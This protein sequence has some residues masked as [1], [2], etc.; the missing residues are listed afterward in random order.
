MNAM[1]SL[2]S[3]IAVAALIALLVAL[4]NTAFAQST[5]APNPLPGVVKSPRPLQ[6]PP[7]VARPGI[8]SP[9]KVPV[10]ADPRSIGKWSA[11]S[12][13]SEDL[14]AALVKSGALKVNGNAGTLEF[15]HQYHGPNSPKHAQM[16][17]QLKAF[18]TSSAS[19]GQG[20]GQGPNLS[21]YGGPV[22]R[23]PIII[24]VFWGFN[25]VNN[26]PNSAM[27]PIGA[28][29][30][31]LSF[32]DYM[33]QSAWLA[34]VN[35]YSQGGNQNINSG[36][37]VVTQPIFDDTTSP[38]ASYGN[39]DVHNEVARLIQQG[40]ASQNTLDIFVVVTPHGSINQD[41]M[42]ANDC[43]NHGS[44][45]GVSFGIIPPTTT[46]SH[47]YTFASVPYLAD[48]VWGCWTSGVGAIT[49]A[50][51]H[52]IAETITDPYGDYF[53]NSVYGGA[54]WIVNPL[55]FSDPG[56]EIGDLCNWMSGQTTF[57]PGQSFT[58]QPLWSNQNQQCV[59]PN[60][61][62]PLYTNVSLQTANGHFVTAV[63]GGGL[64]EAGSSL[65]TDRTIP[66]A[67]E[68]FLILVDRPVGSLTPPHIALLTETGNY[69][70]ANNGG[71]MGGPNT[72]AAPMH[73]DA[74]AVNAWEKFT[75]FTTSCASSQ[76]IITLFN[77][78]NSNYMEHT[79]SCVFMATSNGNFVTTLYG[80]AY[81]GGP[82]DPFRTNATSAQAWET[83]V[84]A[85]H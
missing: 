16:V 8:I 84:M 10:H 36:L 17:A 52:E 31:I 72:S 85:G 80:G 81:G 69:V 68:T 64:G 77:W 55:Q 70:T 54:S 18:A 51:G 63:N 6:S 67:W 22:L 46:V 76:Q 60:G 66:L 25:A 2:N 43:A 45:Q 49:K 20:S 44:D 30:V 79:G 33:V 7:V 53:W 75:F 59:A 23:S 13:M 35:Q 73:T 9:Q 15:H 21:Y 19:G 56:W 26:V 40:R 1:K 24:P 83:F 3:T 14:R 71:G 11:T 50:M 32:L 12:T 65:Q 78:I 37:S 47:N 42:S 28:V 41:L 61:I 58:T 4:G 57:F 62:N 38:G 74:T 5:P 34:T 48:S 39:G 27:D 29:P 82:S